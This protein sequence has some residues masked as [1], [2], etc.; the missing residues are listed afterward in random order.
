[1]IRI[2]IPRWLAIF[3]AFVIAWH[4]IAT[5]PQALAGL[6]EVLYDLTVCK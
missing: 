5:F 6:G 1:M 2:F 4:T 3:F